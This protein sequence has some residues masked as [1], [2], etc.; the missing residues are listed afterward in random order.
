MSHRKTLAVGGF[1]A[2]LLSPGATGQPL[3]VPRDQTPPVNDN[4]TTGATRAFVAN[5]MS[6]K[7]DKAGGSITGKTSIQTS[8]APASGGPAGSPFW[9]SGSWNGSANN[10]SHGFHQ[11]VVVDTANSTFRTV[12]QT[13]GAYS[14]SLYGIAVDHGFGGG[15]T[16][17]G[18]RTAINAFLHSVGPQ[19]ATPGVDGTFHTAIFGTTDISHSMGG[20]SSAPRGEIF[21]LGVLGELRSGATYISGLAGA[22][23]DA[24][25]QTGSSVFHKNILSVIGVNQ[26]AVKGSVT[27]AMIVMTRDGSTTAGYDFGVQFGRLGTLW[28]ID[29]TVG[30]LIGTVPPSSGTRK[31]AYGVDFSGVAFGT[32]AWRSPGFTVGPAGSTQMAGAHA[33]AEY[34]D[35]LV[36]L[37]AGGKHRLV[38]NADGSWT[39]QANTAAAGD[40]SKTHPAYTIE[41][42]GVLSMP[43]PAAPSLVDAANDAEAARAGVGVGEMYRNGSVVMIRVI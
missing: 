28:P 41:P 35:T 18:N 39:W 38:S 15:P 8:L 43:R 26:D 9:V 32:A 2:V 33:F 23:I 14:G 4:S 20:T 3:P 10:F 5:A 13:G 34:Q 40:Y 19:P 17:A 6:L 29:T 11:T 36:A 7:F 42:T 24:S 21:G 22:E 25:A 12:G 16:G 31:A 30:T 27:D 1:L 37:T